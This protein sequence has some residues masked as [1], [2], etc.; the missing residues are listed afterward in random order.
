LHRLRRP[1][2]SL[3]LAG[4]VSLFAAAECHGSRDLGSIPLSLCFFLCY[5]PSVRV[6]SLCFGCDMRYL[7]SVSAVF[8]IDI[9]KS[10]ASTPLGITEE[11]K[12]VFETL[13]GEDP[14]EMVQHYFHFRRWHF[15]RGTIAFVLATFCGFRSKR[16]TSRHD[17]IH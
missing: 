15:L 2:L 1:N 10:L 17:Q 11:K 5:G 6:F 8:P 13:C 14:Q 16:G 9:T 3:N 12:A 7:S 4:S